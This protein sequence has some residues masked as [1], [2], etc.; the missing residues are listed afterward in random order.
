MY[1]PQWET[2][3]LKGGSV[4]IRNTTRNTDKKP[5]KHRLRSQR[6]STIA[7]EIFVRKHYFKKY[8]ALFCHLMI[9]SSQ[10][11]GLIRVFR[12]SLRR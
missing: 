10:A 9:F 3:H 11:L 4:G 1:L 5:L 12:E 6:L 7:M 2:K 8:P